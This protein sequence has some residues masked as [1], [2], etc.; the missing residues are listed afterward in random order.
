MCRRRERLES[1][2]LHPLPLFPPL[3]FSVQGVGEGLEACALPNKR[4][5]IRWD[6]VLHKGAAL[7]PSLVGMHSAP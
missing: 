5:G 3:S 4:D 7:D 1:Y 2:S 6:K